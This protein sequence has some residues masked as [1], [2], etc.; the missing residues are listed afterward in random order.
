ML[1]IGFVSVAFA[2]H[3]HVHASSSV[4]AAHVH[5][6]KGACRCFHGMRAPADFDSCIGECNGERPCPELELLKVLARDVLVVFVAT[7]TPERLHC[8]SQIFII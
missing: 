4:C 5:T 6:G 3:A 8:V 7:V 1:W 2:T